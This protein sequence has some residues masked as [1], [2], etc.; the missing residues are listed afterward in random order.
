MAAGGEGEGRA[1]L[2]I[3]LDEERARGNRGLDE[4][5]RG[6]LESEVREE[7]R[8]VQ[9]RH[10]EAREGDLAAEAEDRLPQDRRPQAR[11][12]RRK[13]LAGEA[14]SQ[15]PPP[16]NSGELRRRRRRRSEEGERV[17]D[18]SVGRDVGGFL[19][20]RSPS[21]LHELQRPSREAGNEG[22]PFLPDH[23]T[24]PDSG[25]LCSLFLIPRVFYF[26]FF[27]T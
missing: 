14:S 26:Y 1:G 12:R 3:G 9:G 22:L 23:H 13:P 8:K 17:C 20:V 15:P 27:I 25:A 19:A 2:A 10:R 18:V 6:E 4:V 7:P 24:P 21:G 16:P 5:E 11:H